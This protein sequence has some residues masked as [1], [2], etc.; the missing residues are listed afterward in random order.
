MP[1][2][3]RARATQGR[4]SSP[5]TAI[6]RRST[7]C[8][9]RAK[10]LGIEVRR[11]RPRGRGR[12][13]RGEPFGVLVQYPAT[14]GARAR[15][16]GAGRARARRRRAGRRR[17]P[18][19]WRSRCSR[20]RAS[21]APTSPSASSQRF[22]V[23]LGYGGPHAAFLATRDE[24]KRQMP[25]RLI[26]VS[27]RRATGK[28]A[29]RLALQTREQHIRREKAT[30]NICTAQVLLAV[31]AGMYAVYHGPDGLQPHRRARPRAGRDCWPP[32]CG[33]SAWTRGHDAVLRHAARRAAAGTRRR[34]CIAAARA[35]R[36]QPARAAAT[37]TVGV[38]ARRDGGGSTTCAT[39]W[40]ASRAAHAAG[41]TLDDAG[42]RLDPRYAEPLRA[43]R[44]TFLTHPVFNQHHSEHE[45]LRYIRAARGARP[46]ADALDDPARLVHDEAQRHRRDDPGDLAGVR[47]AAPVRARRA[48]AG[49]QRA[50]PASWR[51]GWPRSPASRRCRCSPTPA[52]RAS[53]RA[54][55]SSAP[56]TR[57][58]ARRSATSA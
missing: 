8:S 7:S 22:G 6:R 58:A 5:R 12:L 14:D 53:T 25:G 27:Q 32:G 13:R 36:H 21:R 51:R 2:R 23:P 47:R 29:L 17:P 15:L 4:S 52:R 16:R 34:A 45:M 44:A 54:C 3:S 57:A 46:V 24:Y 19:C 9:T 48:G 37:A 35:R 43:A 38:A 50:V 31:M 1:R 40:R 41:S 28:P 11:R 39:C 33:A 56:T 49:L 42:R 26:G 30:S 18:T 20:R 10:P 55:W